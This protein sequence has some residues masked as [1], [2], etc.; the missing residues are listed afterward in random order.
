MEPVIILLAMLVGAEPPKES[1]FDSTEKSH[2]LKVTWG[3]NDHRQ[4]ADP[5]RNA[6]ATL[7]RL[8]VA[9]ERY[10]PIWTTKLVN[11]EAPKE[12]IVSED[13]RFVVTFDEIGKQ[14][15]SV[16]YGENVL[17]VYGANGTLI[18]KF[19][20]EELLTGQEIAGLRTIEG[21]WLGPGT[22]SGIE[23]TWR[24]SAHI[25]AGVLVLTIEPGESDK[26]GAL[27]I[28]VDLKTGRIIGRDRI[29]QPI[30]IQMPRPKPRTA[31]QP[32]PKVQYRRPPE[33]TS[34][35]PKSVY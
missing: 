13:G 18:R 29:G 31:A 4:P 34:P 35:P 16:G 10:L 6:V 8:D 20:L 32:S 17:V 30:E 24:S 15:I 2:R 23:R 1:R 11:D 22:R 27:Q 19:R 14:S 25:D 9:E 26:A 5:T 33:I 7:Y 21:C 3:S 28:R 12:A